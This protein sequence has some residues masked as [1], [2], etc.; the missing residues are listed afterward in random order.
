MNAPLGTWDPR[1]AALSNEPLWDREQAIAWCAE[2]WPVA[3]E[4]GWYIGLTGSTLYRG[5]STKDIDIILY[6][7]RGSEAC[8]APHTQV[9]S[10][11]CECSADKIIAAWKLNALEK[12]YEL[13]VCDAADGGPQPMQVLVGH[14]NGKRIDF[15]IFGEP[16]L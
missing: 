2:K 8:P 12:G 13:G 7:H 4:M 16:V 5:D 6:K 9:A 1:Q 15:M 3:A 10:T 14:W 11:L